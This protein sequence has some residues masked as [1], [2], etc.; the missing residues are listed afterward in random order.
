MGL[1]AQRANV[2]T[3]NAVQPGTAKATWTGTETTEAR[4]TK[5][6]L[7]TLAFV[8]ALLT[9]RL[10]FYHSRADGDG[11]P[12]QPS[13]STQRNLPPHHLPSVGL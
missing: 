1:A 3:L 8:L 7:W 4:T 12:G 6:E 10:D 5:W 2:R 13:S 9:T 11:T